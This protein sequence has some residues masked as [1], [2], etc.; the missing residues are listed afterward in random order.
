M[1]L[2]WHTYRL[3]AFV[4]V[5][6]SVG[7]SALAQ[8]IDPDAYRFVIGAGYTSGGND[9]LVIDATIGEPVTFTGTSLD[10]IVTQGFQQSNYVLS[11]PFIVDL[12]TENESCLGSTDGSVSIDFISENLEAPYSYVWSDGSTEASLVNVTA[13]EYSVTLTD[14]Q[15]FSVFNSATVDVTIS[16]DC[17]PGF[18]TGITPNNDGDNDQWFVDNAEFFDTREVEIFNRYGNKVWETTSYDNLSSFFDGSHQNGQ[19][20]PDGTYYYIATFNGVVYKG[21]I[22]ITR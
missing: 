15:G 10:L 19:Q 1:K 20:L 17:T 13:G 4:A 16:A 22:E 18:Y 14:A 12:V 8:D 21:F 2:L 3:F 11:N 9:A 5:I 6:L 7:I